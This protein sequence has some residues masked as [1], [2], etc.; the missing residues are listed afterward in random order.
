MSYI[1]MTSSV[2]SILDILR[3]A[4]VADRQ[5]DLHSWYVYVPSKS[6]PADAPSRGDTASL[7]PATKVMLDTDMIRH[8]VRT[9]RSCSGGS[10]MS[11][12]F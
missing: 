3:G 7:D 1:R 12:R 4:F 10:V 5:H 9:A 11:T 6:N 8:I 2:P